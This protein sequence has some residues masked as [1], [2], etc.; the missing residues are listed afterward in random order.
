MGTIQADAAS[1]YVLDSRLVLQDGSILAGVYDVRLSLWRTEHVEAE[2]TFSNG[3]EA[4]ELNVQSKNF[5]GFVEEHVVTTASSGAFAL[6]VGA[7]T[8]LDLV[9]ANYPSLFLQVEAKP[10]G[11]DF[12]NWQPIWMTDTP[13]KRLALSPED[14]QKSQIRF[15][16]NYGAYSGVLLDKQSRPQVGAYRARLSLWKSP[17]VDVDFDW[18]EDGAIRTASSNYYGY[19]LEVPFTTDQYGRFVLPF[20]PFSSEFMPGGGDVY[21]QLEIRTAEGTMRNYDLIDPDGDIH[22]RTDRYFVEGNRLVAPDAD[23]I[24]SLGKDEKLL[25]SNIPGG[26]TSRYFELGVGDALPEGY[27][28]IRVRQA[29][30]KSAVLRYNAVEKIWEVSIDG[31]N[32]SPIGGFIN[33]TASPTFTI[34]LGNRTDSRLTLQFG[35]TLGAAL[36]FD[37]VR[38]LFTFNRSVDFQQN[39]LLNAVL[40]NRST[41]PSNPVAGQQYYNTSDKKA[42]YYNGSTWIAMGTETVSYPPFIINNGSSGGGTSGGGGVTVPVPW[43]DIALRTKSIT[44][45][46]DALSTALVGAVSGFK[47]TVEELFDAAGDQSFYRWT[48]KQTSKQEMLIVLEWIVPE[49]FESFTTPNPLSLK[50]RTSSTDPTETSVTVTATKNGA[51]LPLTGA[52]ALTSTTSGEWVTKNIN[53]TG[54]PTVV[55]GEKI[56]FSF[57]VG[58][59]AGES[60]DI[61]QL[62][63]F[64]NGR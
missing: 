55:P 17:N 60:A 38:N 47:G 62:R 11:S 1:V 5:T 51:A 24:A 43:D 18:L 6:S 44:F 37:A 22:S 31:I 61:A 2:D 40:E 19:S 23:H 58:T 15:D 48:T 52:G 20:G 45:A 28:E 42:Y 35:D 12:E 46:G 36:S 53:F 13:G 9:L 57:Q 34:G 50:L 3:T 29:D 41:P 26:T 59:I 39:Q 27:Y 25:V 7:L 33:G 21:V 54:T 56:T 49:D 30:D 14:L 10:S 63:A 8:E 4:P 32:F 16:T 64:Y